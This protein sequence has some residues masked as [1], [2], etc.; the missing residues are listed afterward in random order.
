VVTRKVYASHR[1]AGG[2]WEA[3]KQLVGLYTGVLAMSGAGEVAVVGQSNLGAD[4]PMR[5]YVRPPGQP[6]PGTSEPV[7]TPPSVPFSKTDGPNAVEYDGVGRLIVLD[8]EGFDVEATVRAGG[9]WGATQIIHDDAPGAPGILDLARH[10]SG[11]VGAWRVGS[12]LYVA[13]FNG[14]WETPKLYAAGGDEFTTASIAAD[15]D[16]NIVVAATRIMPAGHEVWAATTTG[17]GAP[18]PNE[19]SR[20]S[21]AAS[22]PRSYRDPA[23]GGGKY[24]VVAW[25]AW[26]GGAV[27]GQAV[28]SGT[29]PDCATQPPPPPPPDP[30]PTPVP[31]QPAPVPSPTPVARPKLGD[32]VKFAA[33]ARKRRL[34]VTLKVPRGQPV[35]RIE[36]RV[37]GRRAVLRRAPKLA[38]KVTL[39][40]LPKR[41]RLDATVTFR[42]GTPLK[43]AKTIK[44]C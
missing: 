24:L 4:D 33:C 17:L 30:T 38:G 8:R 37:N 5:A 28:A 40:K 36:L 21:P 3:T 1:P 6:W 16:G 32:F 15:A 43:A 19:T 35:T 23:A 9:S 7:P 22:G 27:A 25:S 14:A 11:A 29:A 18:W 39:R 44:A 34:V 2:A 20:L 26:N 13:R 10:P 41:F 31:A 42:T 12:D